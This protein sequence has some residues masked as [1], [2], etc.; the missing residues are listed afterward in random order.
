M[1]GLNC[2]FIIALITVLP[3]IGLCQRSN[4]HIV[5]DGKKL[6]SGYDIGVDSSGHKHDWLRDAG[7]EL[8]MTYPNS[9]AWGAVFV[10]VG[11]A[12]RSPDERQ[13]K[14]FSHLT[15]LVISMKGA[16]GGERVDVGIK[17]R[18]NPDDGSETKKTVILT[19]TYRQYSFAL[20]DFTTA[21]LQDLYVVTEFVF[22]PNSPC[23]IFVNSIRFR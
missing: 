22:G 8:V 14:N 18:N 9:Q 20:A 15:T 5:Y 11:K 3:T 23:R 19:N 12:K 10:T 1:K 13:S 4:E 21:D 7:N 6:T 17:D 16:S 2:L